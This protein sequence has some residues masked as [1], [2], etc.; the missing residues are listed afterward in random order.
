MRAV[1][2]SEY[3]KTPA[4]VQQALEAGEAVVIDVREPHE[5]DAG[6][7][8]GTRHLPLDQ[9]SGEA[10]TID[11][12]RPVVFLCHSGVRSLMAAQ[13]FRGSGYDAWSMAGGLVRWQDEGRPLDGSLVH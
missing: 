9:V 7:L 13:A 5:W 8:E 10:A 11:R 4:E 1:S 12:E 3:E 2:A 6:R